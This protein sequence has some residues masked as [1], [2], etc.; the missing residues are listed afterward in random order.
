MGFVGELAALGTSLCFSFGSTLFTLS[1]R[2][3]GSAL[4]NRVRL[5][6]AALLVM[7]LHILTFGQVLPLD[8]GTGPWFWLGL[9]GLVGFVL[10]DAF[11]F[12][13]FVLIGPR[14]SMLMMALA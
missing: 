7:L 8:A 12:Q 13:A 4:V 3:M 10:G 5:L 6:I 1:G 9:S 14:L 2:A 11:L